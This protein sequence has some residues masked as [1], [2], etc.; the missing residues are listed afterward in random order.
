LRAAAARSRRR[1]DR[2]VGM[3]TQLRY[4]SPHPPGHYYS[5]LPSLET[6]RDRE[7]RVW[8]LS[9]PGALAG[10]DLNEPGQ[11]ELLD[12]LSAFHDEDAFTE[13][14]R[15]DRRYF[16]D[17]DFF[18]PADAIVLYTIIRHFAPARIVE[19]G[20]GFSSALMLDTN[21]RHFDNSIEL[22]FIDPEPE[23]LRSLLTGGEAMTIVSRP[24]EEVELSTFAALEADD[25][26]FIDSSHVAKVGSDVNWIFFEIL[27]RVASGVHVHLHDVFFPFE[28]P[29]EYVERGWAWNESY[30]L[31]AF[32]QFNADFRIL[33][34][35]SFLQA[36]YKEQLALKLPLATR[37]P[38]SWPA[39]TSASIWLT[40]HGAEPTRWV[41]GTLTGS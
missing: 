3:A 34:F 32:L 36:F 6:V 4:R 35:P 23:R 5:P 24:V 41:S 25:V 19:I 22:T 21:E 16:A 40:R 7:R 38:R 1:L 2:L 18:G 30:M 13:Q 15:P 29:R 11:L 39:L 17:N 9:P 8:P 33:F 37:H 26:L 31:R 12:R 20:S 28:Y 27:P 10:I 14:K